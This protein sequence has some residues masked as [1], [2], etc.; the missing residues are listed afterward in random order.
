MVFRQARWDEPLLKELSKKGRKGYSLP[1]LD[2]K[3]KSIVGD[4][5]THIP[6]SMLRTSPLTL[7]EM[8]EPEVVRHFVRLSQMNYAID[9]GMY[10]LG[11]CTMKYNPKV[12]QRIARNPKIANLHPYQDE[13]TIQGIL[14]I[15]HDL[16]LILCEIAGMDRFSLA[17]AAGAQGEYVGAQSLRITCET[18]VWETGTKC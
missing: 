2:E 9:L 14:E 8:S 10:P 16:E 15:L 12:S 13:S 17:P 4:A 3:V 5:S 7:P 1:R 6:S 18:K 11:S